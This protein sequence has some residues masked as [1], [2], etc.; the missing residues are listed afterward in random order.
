VTPHHPNST[1]W[2]ILNLQDRAW[3]EAQMKAY[4]P[5]AILYCHAVCD[6][7]K[8]EA[9]PEWAWE[10]NVNQLKN[11]L[12][13]SE[14]GIRF[15]YISSDHV[16][17]GDGSYHEQSTPCP[18]SAYGRTRVAA[19]TLV[20]EHANS[21]V[22]RA[23][24]AI[25]PSL[26]GRSGHLDW[27]RYRMRR[28]LPVTIVEDEYRSAVWATDLAERIMALARS[29]ATGLCHVTATRPVSRVQLADHLLSSMSLRA[30]YR[31]ESRHE[32]HSPHLGRVEL[33]TMRSGAL[34]E[35]LPS[36]LDSSRSTEALRVI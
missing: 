18:I 23:G 15:V 17:G 14:P 20:L 21:M 5:A 29:R 31:R 7:P 12:A 8:C 9:A 32:R 36:V 4:E 22:V 2:P 13:A 16:F 3:I 11:V 34:Y 26:T 6:V 35:P 33:A 19:E 1:G 10:M 25:G 30:E 27:L 24:L 28:N